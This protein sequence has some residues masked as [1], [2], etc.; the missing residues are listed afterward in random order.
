MAGNLES[1][2][3]V[4]VLVGT[5]IGGLMTFAPFFGSDS[6]SIRVKAGFT[7]VLTALLLPL[8]DGSFAP[9]SLDRWFAMELSE[10]AVGLLFGW[11]MQFV[12]EGMQLAGQIMSFQ[13]GFSLVNVID[14]QTNVETT[15]VATFQQLVGILVF[16]QL[17]IHR[18]LLR[19]IAASFRVLPP[20]SAVITE[21]L[22]QVFFRMAT[23]MWRIGVDIALPVLFAT[24]LAD[25]VLAFL[26]KVSPQFP[27]L[28]LGLSVKV[29][30]GLTVLIG[31]IGFWPQIFEREFA[32]ALNASETLLRLFR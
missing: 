8:Y 3:E 32:H 2:L 1:F 21:H 10:A 12:F 19:G 30:L 16:L 13:F 20:G 6:V 23:A 26:G 22:E 11:A 9:V 7:F 28:F 18:S 31:V 5:R 4:A 15:V 29:L 27:V 24:I 25:L 17:G 14:P